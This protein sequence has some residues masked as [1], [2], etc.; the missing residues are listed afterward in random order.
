LSIFAGVATA[1]KG[2]RERGNIV[3]TN[4]HNRIVRAVLHFAA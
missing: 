3:E 4:G 1:V 2:I